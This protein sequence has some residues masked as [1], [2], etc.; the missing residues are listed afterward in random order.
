MFL[1]NVPLVFFSKMNQEGTEMVDFRLH[2]QMLPN[3]STM[4]GIYIQNPNRIIMFDSNYVDTVYDIVEEYLNSEINMGIADPYTEEYKKEWKE[5][6]C[7]Y[8][9]KVI[10][11]CGEHS[12]EYNF[13]LAIE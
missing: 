3:Q 10:V 5:K 9:S 11:Q 12:T 13:N 6:S 4:I 8:N 2:Y 1:N 7:E